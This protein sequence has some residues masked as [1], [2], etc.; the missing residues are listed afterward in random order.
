MELSRD[1]ILFVPK[2]I[3]CNYHLVTRQSR[4]IKTYKNLRWHQ[5][6]REKSSQI[7]EATK[8]RLYLSWE[9]P[10]IF[11]FLQLAFS[12]KHFWRDDL[13]TASLYIACTDFIT[14]HCRL[15]IWT[16]CATG[17]PRNRKKKMCNYSSKHKL[18]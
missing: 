3:P 8:H 18:S 15:R 1:H 14:R 9:T 13:L 16:H 12:E 4:C 10:L 17:I 7:D 5:Q 2:L 11:W 6:Q